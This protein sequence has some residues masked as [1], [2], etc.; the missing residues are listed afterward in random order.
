MQVRFL[1]A[2]YF[3]NALK[4]KKTYSYR[5]YLLYSNDN[6]IR[7][8]GEALHELILMFKMNMTGKPKGH[9]WKT[10]P[11]RKKKK[12]QYLSR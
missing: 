12:E 1:L 11:A 9:G 2:A 3:H 8:D 7:T 10:Q 6:S 4:F 5:L